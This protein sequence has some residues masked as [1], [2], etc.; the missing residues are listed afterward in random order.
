MP[1]EST[2]IYDLPEVTTA[3]TWLSD[4]W[5]GF[6]HGQVGVFSK[7]LQSADFEGAFHFTHMPFDWSMSF[8]ELNFLVR[9]QTEWSETLFQQSLKVDMHSLIKDGI[10]V[11]IG[12]GSN[13]MTPSWHKKSLKESAKESIWSKDSTHWD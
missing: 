13:S 5:K 11:M 9:E 7:S 6:V 2:L 8:E 10:L 3:N 1:S 4:V 12:W